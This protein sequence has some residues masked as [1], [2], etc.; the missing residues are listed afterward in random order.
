MVELPYTP[1]RC[2]RY[3]ADGTLTIEA[4]AG[5]ATAAPIKALLVA[6][7]GRLAAASAV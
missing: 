5:R 2:A 7:L 6:V 1:D 4:L 3:L